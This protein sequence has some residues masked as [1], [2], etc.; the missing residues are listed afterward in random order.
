MCWNAYHAEGCPVATLTGVRHGIPPNPRSGVRMRHAQWSV[1]VFEHIHAS[2]EMY[3]VAA[4]TDGRIW[5]IRLWLSLAP[6]S[7]PG[8]G[9]TTLTRSRGYYS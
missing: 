3:L 6:S 4:H 9:P 1:Y 5:I 2:E 8:L 7:F